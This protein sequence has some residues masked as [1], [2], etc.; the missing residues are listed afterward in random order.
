MYDSATKQ[1]IVSTQSK[2]DLTKFSE[3]IALFDEAGNSIDLTNL[4]SDL[5]A[6]GITAGYVPTAQGDDTV[7]WEPVEIDLSSATLIT[8][9]VSDYLIGT[10]T[11]NDDANAKFLV[12]D[13]LG[14]ANN[15]VDAFT[16]H[17]FASAWVSTTSG[18]ISATGGQWPLFYFASQ[19]NDFVFLLPTKLKAGTWTLQLIG[20][21]STNR[22]IVTI[23]VSPDGSTWTPLTTFDTYAASAGNLQLRN[24]GLTVPANMQ[25]VKISNP[26][27]N[28]ASS[29]YLC[30][31]QGIAGIR[32]G[33]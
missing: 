10:D 11:S 6:T 3:R 1:V 31:F 17:A 27:K 5:D 30:S 21:S 24:T 29:G 18:V 15:T 8:P 26:T 19:S 28:A 14:L 4:N 23:E 13:L 33:V 12:S 32:T 9:V 16:I 2:A 25:Y 22:G 7:E 20:H